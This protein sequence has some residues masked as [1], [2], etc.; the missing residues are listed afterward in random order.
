M[1][2]LPFKKDQLTPTK[3]LRQFCPN[4]ETLK[5]YKQTKLTTKWVHRIDKSLIKITFKRIK[6]D[7]MK[8]S[9]EMVSKLF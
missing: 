5:L 8:K 2:N 4:G 1:N 6:S 7:P 9:K 3:D